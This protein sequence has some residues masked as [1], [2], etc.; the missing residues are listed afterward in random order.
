MVPDV[1]VTKATSPSWPRG[2]DSRRP[3]PV[4]IN[5]GRRGGGGDDALELGP[6]LTGVRRHEDRLRQPDPEHGRDEA[7]PIGQFDHHGLPVCHPDFSKAVRQPLGVSSQF[8]RRDVEVRGAHQDIS[9]GER[10][11][12]EQ[13]G[14]S[15][16][17]CH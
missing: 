6:G 3:D 14:Q 7:G 15:L 8:A 10:V 12:G 1:Q 4:A 9:V 16:H 5:D 17:C 2:F 13:G 11:L